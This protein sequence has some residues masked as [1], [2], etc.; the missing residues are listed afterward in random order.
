MLIGLSTKPSAVSG[1]ILGPLVEDSINAIAGTVGYKVPCLDIHPRAMS[2]SG[3][4]S[5]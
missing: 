1:Q 3:L 5:L 2:A 4:M